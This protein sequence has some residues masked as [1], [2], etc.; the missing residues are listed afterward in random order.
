MNR[1]T[2]VIEWKAYIVENFKTKMLIDIDILMLKLII[3]NIKTD[4]YY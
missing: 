1:C 4:H 2:A 3:M